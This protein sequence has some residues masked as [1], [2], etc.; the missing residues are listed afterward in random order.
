[1]CSTKE[2][3]NKFHWAFKPT[4]GSGRMKPSSSETWY[5]SREKGILEPFEAIEKIAETQ[6]QQQFSDK[7]YHSQDPNL[8]GLQ[9][10][11]HF[12]VSVN[13]AICQ[14]IIFPLPIASQIRCGKSV[15]GLHFTNHRGPLLSSVHVHNHLNEKMGFPNSNHY[16]FTKP[17]RIIMLCRVFWPQRI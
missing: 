8:G 14:H 4:R 5:K 7:A 13:N 10:R 17:C 3:G 9:H 11:V 1:M 15:P 2:M 16:T 12:Q 6:R